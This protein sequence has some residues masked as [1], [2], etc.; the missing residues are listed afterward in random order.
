MRMMKIIGGVLAL[1][2]MAIVGV[3]VIG[4]VVGESNMK[5]YCVAMSSGTAIK[6]VE[7]S[8]QRQGYR[9]HKPESV[10]KQHKNTNFPIE[11]KHLAYM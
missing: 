10:N 1:L 6:D 2:L 11:I 3:V 9:Y 4:F 7:I 5:A 8:A